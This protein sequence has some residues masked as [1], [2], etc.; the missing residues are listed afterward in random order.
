MFQE[1][2]YFNFAMARVKTLR[3][4]NIWN[5]ATF[6]MYTV[7]A[8]IL[9]LQGYSADFR[10]LFFSPK[11]LRVA[12][13]VESFRCAGILLLQWQ[14]ESFA[15]RQHLKFCYFQH[16][17]CASKNPISP[18]VFNR[19][20]K[21]LPQLEDVEGGHLGGKV[22]LNRYFTCAMARWKLC[23]LTLLKFCH[24]QPVHCASENTKSP[25][26]C[27]GFSKS[28][29][30]LEDAEGG[31]L[32]EKF[33]VRR[34]F[35]FAMARW[36][37]CASTTF[38]ILPLSTCTLCQQKFYISKG[39]HPI[40]EIFTSARRSG[41]WALGWKDS[42]EQVFYVCNSNVKTLRIDN[43]WNF[44]TFNM[45][46]L[47]AK[48]LYL[49]RYSTDFRNLSVSSKMLMVGIWVESFRC[50]GSLH[51]Q[52]QG[53]NFAH[54]RHLKF[55]HFQHVHLASKNPISP[56]VFNRFS[57]TLAQLEDVEIG[58]LGGKFQVST[59]FTLAIA[60][61]KLCAS[62][63]FEI[64][65]LSTCTRCR[66]KSYICKAIQPIFEIFSSARRCWGWTFVWKDSCEQV[67]CDCSSM[68]KTLRIDN[69]WNFCHFQHVHF[70]NLKSYI[71]KGVQP[72]FG[73]T[74]PELEDVEGG[75]LGG[76][77]QARRYFTF[78]MA[79]WKLCVSTTF[80]ILPLLTC[81]LCQKKSYIS[82]GIP[83]IFEIFTSARR[84]RGW[85]FGW[86]VSGAQVFYFCNGKVKALR[87][88]NI[89]NFATFNM[90]TVPAKIL[91]LRRY[92]TDFRNLYLSSKMWRVGIWV[93]RFMWLGILRLQWQ[94]E[95]FAHRQH[96][97]FCHFQPVH[98][99]DKS[100]VSAKVFHRFSKSLPQ[101]EDVEGGHL[102]GKF[103]G[104]RYFT[105]AMARWK[106]C[107]SATFEILP[108]LTCTLCQQ[109]SYISKGIKPIFVIFASARRCWGRAFGWQVSR[110]QGFY[111]CNRKLK[112]LRI[113]NIWNFA[114]F[115]LYTVP[116]KILYLQRYST[117]F[118]NLSRSS[119][120]LMGCIWVECFSYTGMLL[121]QWQGENVRIDNIWNFA[122]FNLYT[123]PAKILYLQSYSTDFSKSFPQLEDVEGGHLCGKIHV[124]RYFAIA[125]AW[126]KLCAS[127][128]FKILPLLT[129]TLCLQKSYI[130]KGIQPILE[131]FPQLED[132]EGGHLGGKFQSHRYFTFAMARWK[133]C[134]LATFKIL[135]LLTCTLGQKK[136]YISKGIQTD[137]RNL[138]LSL[139]MLTVSIRVKSF[140]CAGILPL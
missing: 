75:H 131:I 49:Q 47:P 133:L 33:Q 138:C 7:P 105:F 107:A 24:F 114:T 26:V 28:L 86:K 66:Q 36:K 134:A 57:K 79:R 124:S 112:T 20:S 37:F 100:P 119:K 136:S 71:S 9:Y 62:T 72:I 121:L 41:G 109:K 83:P 74:L 116:A 95:N 31:H 137:F 113:D 30:E 60:T 34:Y 91:Y 15:L 103:Q 80:E 84:C 140:T 59:C 106:L 10:N 44:A 21:S 82:K 76:K 4:D 108:L 61:W 99:A 120:M 46:T 85:P 63:T 51:L 128:T 87:I 98:C 129:C 11:M 25:K 23:A 18:K 101:L 3:I 125:V 54:R 89:S 32:G 110:A 127:T 135:P 56:K 78:A 38:E 55:C 39:I 64:L 43:I 12:I 6:N 1:R 50:A 14:G 118:R 139:K 13:W 130:S 17:H 123:V 19:F 102:G 96:L 115:K 81:T 92:S 48:I 97:K 65:P 117:D 5:F 68:V 58:H 16:V 104:R 77:F 53:E 45:Y 88:D 67:F 126:W 8:K 90:Y 22:Q 132:V 69:I 94:G 93:E 70:A 111:F 29:T 2:R 35:T 42:C 122:T 52:W 40:F 73:K 27:N